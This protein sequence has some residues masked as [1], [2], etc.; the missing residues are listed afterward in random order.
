MIID[1]SYELTQVSDH[2]DRAR[3]KKL[4]ARHKSYAAR[5]DRLRPP[6]VCLNS[7]DGNWGEMDTGDLWS[8]R[9]RNEKKRMFGKFYVGFEW[10]HVNLD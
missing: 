4:A 3:L 1:L 7:P 9:I 8:S 10:C 2:S 5:M 6:P